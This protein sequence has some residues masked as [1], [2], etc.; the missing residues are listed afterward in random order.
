MA[1]SGIADFTRQRIRACL[2]ILIILAVGFLSPKLLK[3]KTPLILQA[4]HPNSPKRGK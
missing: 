4:I 1:E 2:R 3:L